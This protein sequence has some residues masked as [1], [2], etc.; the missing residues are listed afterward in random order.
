MVGPIA[1]LRLMGMICPCFE[2][3]EDRNARISLLQLNTLCIRVDWHTSSNVHKARVHVEKAA[4]FVRGLFGGGGQSQQQTLH[5]AD[6]EP[7]TPAQIKVVDAT[8]DSINNGN[9]YP[10]L[11]LKPLPKIFDVQEGSTSDVEGAENCPPSSSSQ[12]KSP[13]RAG[14]LQNFLQRQSQAFQLDIPLHH[15][16]RVETIDP[17]MLVLITKDV[18]STD[19]KKTIKE[20]AR[21]SF[22]SA[23]DRD[24]VCHDINVLVEWQKNRQPDMEEELPAEGIKAKAM[25]A[26]HFARREMEM[27]ET[28]RS[29]E[30]RKAKFLENS[31]G[32]KY[33]AMAMANRAAEDG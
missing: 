28:K 24:A 16:L 25:K 1:K 10:E 11:Q 12:G 29:R 8:K 14:G 32:L 30:Q 20:A 31:G 6:K 7:P 17:T 2:K 5:H 23:D 22:T 4:G 33:T 27:R 19:D 18:H 26:A 13:V 21:I 15:I 9:P 3:E